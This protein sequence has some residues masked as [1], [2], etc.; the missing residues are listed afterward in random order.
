MFSY[1]LILWDQHMAWGFLWIGLVGFRWVL[2][3]VEEKVLEYN[4]YVITMTWQ[5]M[6]GVEKIVGS[7][8]SDDPPLIICHFRI[9]VKVVIQKL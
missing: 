1:I 5:T 4:F 6:N 3:V 7:Y 8:E 9:L 2:W